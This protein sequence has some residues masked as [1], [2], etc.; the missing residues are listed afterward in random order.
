MTVVTASEV[1][2]DGRVML[3]G[4]RQRCILDTARECL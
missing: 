4:G 3:E 2:D 1:V